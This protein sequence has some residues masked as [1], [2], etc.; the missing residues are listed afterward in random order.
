MHFL[1]SFR[2]RR[3]LSSGLHTAAPMLSTTASNAS[4]NVSSACDAWITAPLT[5]SCGA[6]NCSNATGTPTCICEP[7]WSG[8]GDFDFRSLPLQD[9]DC[10][11]YPAFFQALYFIGAFASFVGI[12]LCGYTW[13]ASRLKNDRKRTLA[14]LMCTQSIFGCVLW[15][16]RGLY[17]SQSIGVDPVLTVVHAC[18]V[19]GVGTTNSYAVGN[20]EYFI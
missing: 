6:G 7:G 10:D 13:W 1:D 19:F 3:F 16:F 8:V 11:K 17:P 18:Y 20:C 2:F 15:T 4:V 9:A 12:W 14:I 5:K